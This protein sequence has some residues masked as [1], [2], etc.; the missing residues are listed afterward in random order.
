[1]RTP[2]RA[3]PPGLTC[4]RPRLACA[5]PPRR[6]PPP[7]IRSCSRSGRPRTSTRSN[8]YN[9][10]LVVG[11]EVF[12][13][14]YDLLVDFGPNLEPAPGFADTW[15]RVGRRD[16]GPSTS[17]T[18][19]KWSDGQPATVGRR[20]L[21]VG[22]RDR[23]DQ[24]RD[25]RR[26]R[27]PRP[28]VKDAGVTKVECP[29]ATTMVA[30]TTDPSDRDPPDL[31]PDPAQAR[32]G[33]GDYKTIADAQV[34]PPL[35]GTGPYTVAEWKTGQFARFVRNPNYWGKQGSADEVVIQFFQ[36]QT[37]TMVQALKTGELD[38]AHGVNAD[39]FKPAQ[40]RPGVHRGRRQGQ[41]LDPARLQH[42][43]HGHRQ[44]DQGRRA[45]DEGAPGSRPSAT[46]SA[47]RS[48][49]RPL[50][51][52]VLGGYGDVGTT[53]VPPVLADWH[54]E[55]D[56]PR[57][58]DIDTG[59]AEA[60][61]RRLPA[62]RERQAPRQGRQADQPAARPSRTPNDNYPKAAQFIQDWYGQLGIK[63]NVAESLDSDT[64][65]RPDPAARGR[66]GTGQLRHR[67]LGLGG[68]PGPERA[69]RRSSGATQIGSL[70]GQPVLQPG[71]R[72]AV[73]PGPAEGAAPSAQGDPGPD[74][75]P[76]LR[77]GAVPHPLLRRQP[78][79]LPDR[80]VRRLAE[81]ADRQRHAVLHLR[82]AR[83]HAADRR[84]GR[85]DAGAVGVRA[86]G[87]RRRQPA[88]RRR[89]RR[90]AGTRR[91][92]TRQLGSSSTRRS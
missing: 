24:G 80:P 83:L 27:L 35:V 37:D 87:R 25:E 76:D 57:T 75:E 2:A 79:R 44:D 41:R 22:P 69:A 56:H 34:R 47:T 78:G 45:V 28:D 64:L 20:L 52:R 5:A 53:I 32:L 43:R 15:E 40:G 17:A 54:V 85:A 92:S 7:R 74:A 10:A 33:Q 51:D 39:Q 82:H 23:C 11:Y 3:M 13:L 48:T 6:R 70:V 59:Q 42:L 86:A 68:R 88:R 62:R 61:R 31:R 89:R 65:E 4:G 46:R 67:D 91:A 73:R 77:P 71:L 50:V 63:V 66:D 38:Y 30:Y 36:D 18:G 81:P 49:T 16:R 26:L 58:F 84:Q 55:P 21:L 14:T 19:M 72:Q 90:R 60:R 8:P 12:R 9:T 1:M 29:D